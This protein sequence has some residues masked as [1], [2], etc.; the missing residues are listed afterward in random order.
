MKVLRAMSWVSLA[1]LLVLGNA[2]RVQA[3]SSLS[4]NWTGLYLGLHVGNGWGNGDMGVT[5]L[6]SAATFVN[7][8]PSIEHPTVI[9]PVGGGQVGFN[10]QRGRLVLG[11]ETDFSG[12][13]MGGDD[14]V[15]PIVQNNGTPFPGPAN[16]L[17][18]HQDTKWIGTLRPRVGVTV[19]PNVLLY[20]TGGLAYGHVRYSANTDFRTAGTEQ[21]PAAF[22]KT[23]KGWTVGAGVECAIASRWTVK[24][25]YLYYNL[26]HES[27]LA[28]PVPPLPPFQVGYDWKTTASLVTIGLNF[29]F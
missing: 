14:T 24:T 25:E 2:G 11:A 8:K 18:T 26:G 28:N 12:C 15:H 16:H 9:G 17:T 1:A 6:P 19:T 21:Y 3:A 29:K 20:G 23:K 5:P 10:W 7:L 13:A 4:Y 27:V 22:S